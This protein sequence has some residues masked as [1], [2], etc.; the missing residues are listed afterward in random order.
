MPSPAAPPQGAVHSGDHRA[1]REGWTLR[2]RVL[3]QVPAPG[4]IRV[5]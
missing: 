4:P 3:A 2:Q 1:R 5:Q